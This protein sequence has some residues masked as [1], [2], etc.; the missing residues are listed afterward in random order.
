M[1][2]AGADP[3]RGTLVATGAGAGLSPRGTGADTCIGPGGAG[4]ALEIGRSCMD[5]A[6]ADPGP[7]GRTG[8]IG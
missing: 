7:L 4:P 6:G 3:E 1:S 2:A 5:G 8:G